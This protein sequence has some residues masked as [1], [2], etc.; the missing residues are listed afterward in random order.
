M[1]KGA[2]AFEEELPHG[3]ET[4]TKDEVAAH[5]KRFVAPILKTKITRAIEL[6]ERAPELLAEV[7]RDVDRQVVKV[8]RA[9]MKRERKKLCLTKT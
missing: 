4:W 6:K 3:I 7:D 5:F 8:M 1:S 2:Y 9:E